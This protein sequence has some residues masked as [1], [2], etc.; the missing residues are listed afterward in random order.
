MLDRVFRTASEKYDAILLDIDSC[1]RRGQPVL[2]GT[3]SIEQNEHLSRLLTAANLPH[4]VLNAKQHDR[5]AD[6]IAQAGKL[7]AITIATNMA[8]RGTDIILGGNLS[9]E[10]AQIR[11]D[12][13]LSDTEKQ[14]KLE[15]LQLTWKAAHASVL[16]A[17]GLHIIGTERHESRR[18]DNQLRGRSGRQGDVGSSRFYLSLEDPLLRIF[19][20]ARVATIM[21]KLQV[22]EGEAIEHV[23]VSRAIENAQHNVEA[24]NFEMRKQLLEYDDVASAQRKIIYAQRDLVLTSDSLSELLTLMREEVLRNVIEEYAPVDSMVEQW[25]VMGL[26]K[27][28]TLD[29]KL[30]APVQ[31]WLE[32]DS[33]LGQSGLV[34]KCITLAN[35]TYEAKV[36]MVGS[37]GMHQFEQTMLLNAIDTH[38]RDQ[39]AGLAYL[40]EGIN[41]RTYAQKNPMQEY[42]KEAFMLYSDMLSMIRLDAVQVTLGT[43]LRSVA[44]IPADLVE[45]IGNLEFK[46]Q[47]PVGVPGDPH[48]STEKPVNFTNVPRNAAC[49]C[50]S[51]NKF[52][53]CHGKLKAR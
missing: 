48:L 27:V 44:E 39:L 49:P 6:I 17:G 9:R 16:A 1:Y 51:G 18:V 30:N 32:E 40:R 33:T 20:A 28:L 4:A 52:K 2:V 35:E 8:G 25:D 13:S 7:H 42:K 31:T 29:F 11:Q 50:G 3:T 34:A 46:H 26:T 24:R 19:A 41:L 23:W 53:A 47:T 15:Q 36:S 37:A 10:L 38:W 14:A 5:E 43:Q 45:H 22:A 21:D 12:I